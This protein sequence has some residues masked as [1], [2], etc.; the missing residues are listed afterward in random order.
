MR[1]LAD[2]LATSGEDPSLSVFLQYGAIGLIAAVAL[3]AVKA[4]YTKQT[5]E[6]DR[7]REQLIARVAE[8]KSRADRL[9]DELGKLNQ[10]VQN[11]TMTALNEATRAVSDAISRMR[12]P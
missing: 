6:R 3:L 5:Q 12:N 10:L 8:E 2:L 11:Q 4:L 7:E 1:A 9:E